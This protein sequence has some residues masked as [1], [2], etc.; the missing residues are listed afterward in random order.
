MKIDLEFEDKDMPVYT[1]LIVQAKHPLL[2]RIIVAYQQLI[3]WA[4]DPDKQ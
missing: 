1:S 2:Q 3:L 4:D